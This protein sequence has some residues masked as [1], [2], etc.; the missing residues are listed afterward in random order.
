MDR[1]VVGRWQAWLCPMAEGASDR[2][3]QAWACS[4]RVLGSH[5]TPPNANLLL[6]LC[7]RSYHWRIPPHAQVIIC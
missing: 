2:R 4:T 7:L 1:L 5:A 3:Q 6:L